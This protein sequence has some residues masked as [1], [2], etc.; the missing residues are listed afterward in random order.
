MT[1][2]YI[3]SSQIHYDGIKGCY[4]RI[5]TID[6][7]P[8]GPL[9]NLTRTLHTSKLSPFQDTSP[10]CE[11]DH[12]ILALYSVTNGKI[13]QPCDQA[14]LLSFLIQNGYTVDSNVTTIFQNN[15]V[16]SSNKKQIMFVINYTPITYV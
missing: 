5:M 1:E 10:C 3:I 14:I 4:M 16:K 2:V 11:N 15:R 6:R 12:C 7:K 8:S 9:A 13:L